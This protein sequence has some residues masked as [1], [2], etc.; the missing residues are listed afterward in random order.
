[1][2]V[3]KRIYSTL[4]AACLISSMILSLGPAAIASSDDR[5]PKEKVTIIHYKDGTV[6]PVKPGGGGNTA[7]YSLLGKGVQWKSL[8]VTY[9]INPTNKDGLSSTFVTTAI[10]SAA[11][12]WDASTSAELFGAYAVDT[13]ATYDGNGNGDGRNEMVFG[14][15]SDS[16]I[17]AVTTIWGYFS[18]AVQTRAIT[19]TDILFNN[20]YVWGD[21]AAN[22]AVMDLQ[23]IATHEIGHVSGLNDL[24]STS[25]IEQTMYGY[26][27]QGETKKRSLN[28]GDIAG[29][30]SLY[31]N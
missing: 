3:M 19:E 12:T 16:N 22:P 13:T 5:G 9:Y 23:N 14:S 7:L 29:I 26:S 6:K 17:I 24:Y 30:K 27:T 21:A 18:G 31:G 25:A 28:T 10:S 11:E 2:K 15:L 8:P 1:M 4:L 20:Y